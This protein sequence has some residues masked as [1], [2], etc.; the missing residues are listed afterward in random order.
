MVRFLLGVVVCSAILSFFVAFL[1]EID[2]AAAALQKS[3][4]S[5]RVKRVDELYNRNCARCHGPDGR[6]D[7]P[8]GQVF[9]SPDFTDPEWWKENSSITSTKSLRLIVTGGKAGMP[10]FGKKLSRAEIN[11]LVD[12]VRKFRK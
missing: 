6:G 10:A 12:R 3:Q 5:S 11:L 7:T 1:N 4:T 8:L 2:I 9:N